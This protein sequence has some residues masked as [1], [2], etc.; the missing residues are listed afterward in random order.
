MDS[1]RAELAKTAYSS[2]ESAFHP[3]SGFLSALEPGHPQQSIASRGICRGLCSVPFLECALLPRV[4]RAGPIGYAST[5]C[6][7]AL[8]EEGWAQFGGNLKAFILQRGAAAALGQHRVLEVDIFWKFNAPE[9]ETALS[10]GYHVW[11][12]HEQPVPLGDHHPLAIPEHLPLK[13][14]V[15]NWFP[16]STRRLV[17]KVFCATLGAKDSAVRR[18]S[19][20]VQARIDYAQQENPGTITDLLLRYAPEENIADVKKLAARVIHLNMAATH[21][22]YALVPSLGFR[23]RKHL[24]SGIFTTHSLFELA[25]IEPAMVQRIRDEIVAAINFEGGVCNKA[26]VDKFY[27]LDS[28]LKE[29]GRFHSLFAGALSPPVGMI[30][31]LTDLSGVIPRRTP[32]DCHLRRHRPPSRQRCG[33]RAAAA[34]PQRLFC[35][36]GPSASAHILPGARVFGCLPVPS[37]LAGGGTLAEYLVIP[38][39]CVALAP[40]GMSSPVAASLAGG[41]QT[42]ESVVLEG[43]IRPGTRVLVNRGSGGVGSM[44]IQLAKAQG[45]YVVATCSARTRAM[46]EGLGTD[47]AVDY[48]ANAPLT[49][50]LAR[51]YHSRPFEYIFD[52]IGTQALFYHSPAYLRAD[53]LFVNVGNFEGLF[54][55]VWRAM[56]STYLPTILGG[57]PRRYNMISTTPNGEKAAALAEM[58]ERGELRVVI[59]EI[60]EFRDALKA[61]DRMLARNAMGKIVVKV[62]DL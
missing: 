46:V 56:L 14:G 54:L 55:T 22:S 48:R 15:L 43:K 50:F 18:V 7:A 58:V 37:L 2:S 25:R 30:N 41:G 12:H 36:T 17:W 62:Q 9:R 31:L 42:A 51:E 29:T 5:R 40:A 23:G 59:D 44:V 6:C 27:L 60:F 21:T 61:Y 34:A 13:D 16:A 11:E 20:Y 57:V 19:P 8:V 26:A 24:H 28:L 45:A 53:G 3:L 52:T 47:E 49:A 4:G 35:T 10:P 32:R 39:S 33:P 38:A 1:E